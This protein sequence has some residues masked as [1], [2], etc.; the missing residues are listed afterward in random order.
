[1]KIEKACILGNTKLNYSWFVKTYRQGLQLNGIETFD[2]DYKST[3]LNQIKKI[4]L[5]K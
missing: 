4:L 3:P 5:S 2:I 1:M